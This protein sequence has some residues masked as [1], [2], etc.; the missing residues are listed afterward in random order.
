MM[1]GTHRIGKSEGDLLYGF[2]TRRFREFFQSHDLIEAM[3]TRPD[4]S[5]G[6][7]SSQ[8]P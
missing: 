8:T 3:K 5:E 2:I 6:E 1:R 4:S 7:P